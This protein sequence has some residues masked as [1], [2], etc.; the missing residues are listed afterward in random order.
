M[1]DEILEAIRAELDILAERLG[2]AAY[3]SLRAQLHRGG[4]P[5]RTDPDLVREKLAV[6]V[7]ATPSNAL[8]GSWPRLSGPTAAPVADDAGD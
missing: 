2:D 7:P 4:K 1:S 3:E 5:A 6:S 8:R